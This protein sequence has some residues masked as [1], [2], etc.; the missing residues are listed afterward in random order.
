MNRLFFLGSLIVMAISCPTVN[1]A[2]DCFYKR[3]DTNKDGRISRHEI[4]VAIDRYLPWYERYPFKLFG[5]INKVMSDCDA[6]HDGYLTKEEAHIM[7]K[8]CLESCFK[9]SHA[10]SSFS[11]GK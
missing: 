8:T 3:A 6:N 2:L 5:G 10:F 1:Q 4:Q 9:R 7:H 11:C